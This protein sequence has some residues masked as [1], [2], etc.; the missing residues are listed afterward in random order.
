MT[1]YN[2]IPMDE[3]IE[4]AVDQWI[5]SNI[6]YAENMEFQYYFAQNLDYRL[7]PAGVLDAA[8]KV[9]SDLQADI[10]YMP[11]QFLFTWQVRGYYDAHQDECE[12]AFAEMGGYDRGQFDGTLDDAMSAA[13][14]GAQIMRFGT[15]C[16]C[17]KAAWGELEGALNRL[18]AGLTRDGDG[19][20][21]YD[22]DVCD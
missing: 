21:Y 4:E 6:I 3:A 2:S 10:E 12:N 18:Q 19:E 22:P 5:G 17:L 16:E 8:R 13:V 20:L 11:E 14:R 7:T 15:D 9:L 1:E